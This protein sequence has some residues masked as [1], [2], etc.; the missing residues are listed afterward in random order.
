M[1]PPQQRAGFPQQ[2]GSALI[3][4]LTRPPS[5]IATPFNNSPGMPPGGGMTPQQQQVQ[6]QQQVPQQ[7]VQQQQQ[8]QQVQQQQQQ[9]VQQQQAVQQQQQQMRILA[10]GRGDVGQ[11]QQQQPPQIMQQ[12]QQ[13][14]PFGLIFFFHS[15]CKTYRQQNI[16]AQNPQLA[17]QAVMQQQPNQVMAPNPQMQPQQVFCI[18]VSR[19]RHTIWKG[20]LEWV[21]K[22]KN[23]NDPQK[24][25]RHVPCSVSTLSKDGEPELK[26]DS[27]P[28]KLIMQLMPKQLIVTVGGTYLKNSKSVLFHPTVCESLDALT[29]I[30]STGY[31]GC[32][33]FNSTPSS[34][35]I[36]ILI[37]LYTSEKRTYLGFIP[38]DQGAFVDRLRKIIQQQKTT[39]QTRQAQ[40]FN[41]QMVEAA[42]QENLVKIQKLRQ[43]LEAAQQQDLQYRNQLEV[44]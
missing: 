11:P 21:E 17:Q 34:C 36:K 5:A 4:Q 42:R 9:Q 27:W 12:Q 26:A 33:H 14:N 19:E 10:A 2:P 44:R 23:P 41:N 37:L 7:Q 39:G 24:L 43:T 30:M 25:T 31:A 32:V 1:M 28:P 29:K 20:I 18:G 3:E 40:G 22:P 8:Q 16:L 6:Q 35:D 15:I 38:N 13:G